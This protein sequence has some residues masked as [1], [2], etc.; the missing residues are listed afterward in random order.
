MTTVTPQAPPDDRPAP[1]DLQ[2]TADELAQRHA[3]AARIVDHGEL[4]AGAL[5]IVGAAAPM[6]G[7]A[8]ARGDTAAAAEHLRTILTTCRV[9]D[10]VT[11][12]A[13]A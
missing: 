4:H 5:G 1:A 11:A 13:V 9:V 8:L 6:L 2:P 7:R 12:V 3:W 10:E